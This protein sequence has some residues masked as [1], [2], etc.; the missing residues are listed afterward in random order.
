MERDNKAR[1]EVKKCLL[2][3]TRNF[4]SRQKRNDE[5][6]EGDKFFSTYQKLFFFSS[7]K[8]LFGGKFLCLF[9][10]NFRGE[11]SCSLFSLSGNFLTRL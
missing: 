3:Y 7:N 6:R 5:E 2:Y 9:G 4:F 10:R 11:A 1:R 8:I